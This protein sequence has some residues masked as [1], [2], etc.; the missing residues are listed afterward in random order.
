MP[1]KSYYTK[2]GINLYNPL[3]ANTSLQ[4]EGMRCGWN[5]K[6]EFLKYG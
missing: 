6:N 5:N 3:K 2:N 1:D 4:K